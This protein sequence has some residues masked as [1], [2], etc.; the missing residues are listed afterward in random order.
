MVSNTSLFQALTLS[1]RRKEIREQENNSKGWERG[2]KRIQKSCQ[3]HPN[4]SKKA[5]HSLFSLRRHTNL[6]K[7]KTYLACK[8]FNTMICPILTYNSEIWGVYMPNQSL[9]TGT[10]HKSKRHTSN[11]A[12]VTNVVSR[13]ELGHLPLNIT[14]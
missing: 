8:I 2:R 6:S 4:I 7:I 5:F 11:F 3:C 10:P 13:A 14:K 9:R 1:G 12:N